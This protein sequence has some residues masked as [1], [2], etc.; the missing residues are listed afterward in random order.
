MMDV[1][2]LGWDEFVLIPHTFK[3][4]KFNDPD[5]AKYYESA[6][7]YRNGFSFTLWFLDIEICYNK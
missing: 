2:F 1:E 6:F 3:R 5:L 7:W 4:I